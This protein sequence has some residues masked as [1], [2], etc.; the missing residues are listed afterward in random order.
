MKR[1]TFPLSGEPRP[2]GVPKLDPGQA[3]GGRSWLK[4][5][6]RSAVKRQSRITDKGGGRR[7]RPEQSSLK[8]YRR[9]SVVKI[10]YNRQSGKPWRERA[11]YLTREHAQK[12]NEMGVGFDANHDQVDI[13]AIADRWQR[14]GD[15]LLWRFI[16]SP[17]DD[18]DLKQHIR[19][20]AAQMERDLGTRLEWIAMD[21]HPQTEN[22]HV[23]MFVR[24]IRDDGQELKLDRD[25]IAS[26]I[27]ELSQ[28]LIEKELGP[29]Q[30]HEM[31]IARERGIEGK[32]WTDID[33]ALQRRQ[34]A[35]RVVAYEGRTPFN[36]NSQ[37][38]IRQEVERL[39][40][41]ERIQLAKRIGESTWQLAPDHEAKLRE[42][43]R[44]RDIIKRLE[45]ERKQGLE[46]DIG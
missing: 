17:D 20:V 41:L 11:R 39:D 6:V 15:P 27:R 21:H 9:R 43:Q 3:R 35:E 13:V 5:L 36:E 30:E 24:G 23:H 46:R 2:A 25:Y 12:E 34:D 28:S 1:P 40:F 10:S 42:M 38:R 44:D 45:R 16:I 4:S 14:E 19:D 18:V 26:G 33:R 31:L 37:H 29:R 22:D 32:H 7:A 8:V